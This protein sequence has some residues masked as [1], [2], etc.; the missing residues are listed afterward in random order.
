MGKRRFDFNICVKINIISLNISYN[1]VENANFF[2][3]IPIFT[4]MVNYAG[5]NRMS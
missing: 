5:S 2:P 1:T 4:C 3:N